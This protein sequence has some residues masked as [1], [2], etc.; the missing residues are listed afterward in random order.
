MQL[1]PVVWKY[2]D[3]ICVKCKLPQETIDHF[4]S[5]VEYGEQINGNW[6]DIFKYDTEKLNI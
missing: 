2:S 5:C 1:P 3:D 4:V 6:K